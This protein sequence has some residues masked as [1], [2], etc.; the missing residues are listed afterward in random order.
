MVSN[1][2]VDIENSSGQKL[3]SGPLRPSYF[4]QLKV[5]DE[6]GEFECEISAADPNISALSEKRIAICRYIDENGSVQV[7]GGGVIDRI[8]AT[9]AED[10][11]LVYKVSGNDLSRE[12]TYRSVKGLQLA[13]LGAGVTN[14]PAQI[15]ALA[16]SGWSLVGGTTQNPVYAGFDGE[17]ILTAL[18][19][20]GEH[21][22]EHWRLGSGR[23]IVWLGPATGFAS[24]GV[25]AVQTVSDP[26]AAEDVAGLAI[27]SSLEEERDAAEIIT[28]VYPRGSGNGDA[29]VTLAAATASAPAGYTLNKA[30]N[31]LQNNA[32]HTQY[33]LI[34]RY[35]DFKALGPLSNTDLDVQNAAN[36]L[37]QA[38]YQHMERYKEPAKFYSISFAQ[39]PV[40][41]PGTVM[42]VV[43]RELLDGVIVYDLNDTYNI[44]QVEQELSEAGIMTV[45]AVIATVDRQPVSD[46]EFLAGQAQEA[47]VFSVHPQLGASVDSL[48]WRDEMDDSHDASF[49]FWLG[50]EYTAIQRAV[51]RFRI[52]PLRSTVR[53]VEAGGGSTSTSESGGGGSVTSAAG[54]GQ[55]ADGG[56]HQHNIDVYFGGADPNRAPVYYD[57]ALGA[58][59]A[60][61]G[62]FDEQAWAGV[63]PNHEHEIADHTHSVDVP[64]HTHQVTIP[65][66]THPMQYGIYEESGANTLE[67]ADLVIKVN[68]GGDLRE[69]CV[70]LGSGWYELD[71][72]AEVVNEIYRPA[73]ESNVIQF[74]T[75]TEK[76][77]R[78]EAQ[79][80]IRGVVQAVALS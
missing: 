24:S 31:Y 74:S 26:V 65:A 78:L 12:L 52:Q 53:S 21:I 15:M 73:Q 56:S 1:F 23:Q 9:R 5:L 51:L 42:R 25:R 11:S 50:D 68:S 18:I 41:E 2:W 48:S 35:L 55:T 40:L 22:G 76:T 70:D 79:L 69:Q 17:S 7:Y 57:S 37:L 10:G 27:I 45:G 34:E 32:A 19:N 6:S 63:S 3:G 62:D 47:K 72:T 43:Y 75:A 38:T 59:F 20:V 77:A 80:T 36:M 39:C 29:I 44:I 61:N 71:I 66:H 46:E 30:E 58:F 4:R 14:G 33:G 16:P 60:S 64:A 54:G 28:R 67:L 8:T 13:S 49:R